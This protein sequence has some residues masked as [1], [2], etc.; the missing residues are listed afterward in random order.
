MTLKKASY[1]AIKYACM[2]FHYAKRL[3]AQPMVGFS[4]FENDEWCGVIVFNNGI[5]SIEKPFGVH[6]G[7]VAELARVALNGKQSA[8][9]KAVSIALRLFS[10]Q[11]P[12]VKLVVSYADTDQG[13][14]GVIYQATNW[15]FISQH[16]TGDKFIN[17]KTDKEIHSRSHSSTGINKQFGVLKR[18][19]KTSDLIKIKCGP[20]NK[21]L[22]FFEKKLRETWLKKALPYPKRIKH[23]ID[24]VHDFQS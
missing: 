24:D 6:K 17:P 11:N 19:F 23:S 5:G 3:P 13:H 9:S 14:S 1:K 2:N 7:Q 12:L 20:K 16:H 10:A 15:L 8:T 18:V 21:Y 4:C 22:Y